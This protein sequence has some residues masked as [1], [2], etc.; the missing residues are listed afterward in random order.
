MPRSVSWS[1]VRE[2]AA[3][4]ASQWTAAYGGL[5]RCGDC[6]H[7]WAGLEVGDQQL[8]ALYQQ[9]YFAGEEYTDYVGDRESL[10]SNFDARLRTLDRFLDPAR[11]RRLL[12]VGCAYGFFL[13][14]ARKR[15]AD[16]QG[17]DISADAV[18]YA[19]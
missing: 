4:G 6:G 16:V 7:V 2:C 1:R 17:I 8:A 19:V 15:F 18:R 5:L 11:H 13:A 10:T 9:H 14:L 12:E 3:C